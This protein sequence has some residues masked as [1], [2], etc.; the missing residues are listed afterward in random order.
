MRRIE[1]SPHAVYWSDSSELVTL[2]C[3]DTFFVLRFSKENYVA[4]VQSGQIEDDGVESAFE[5]VADIS[6]RYGLSLI[7]RYSSR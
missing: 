7:Y 2:A 6:A 3:E 5:V 1:V 4:A